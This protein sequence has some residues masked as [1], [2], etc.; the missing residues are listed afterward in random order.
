MG[1]WRSVACI[2]PVADVCDALTANRPCH[3]AIAPDKM[4]PIMSSDV[5]KAFDPACFD[6]LRALAVE[7]RLVAEP[8]RSRAFA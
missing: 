7:D 6:A 2:V 1:V 8:G 3:A 4:L 5:G